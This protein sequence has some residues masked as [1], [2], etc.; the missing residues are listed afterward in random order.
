MY[1]FTIG[2]NV[3]NTNTGQIVDRDSTE[4]GTYVEWAQNHITPELQTLEF[5]SE[6][7]LYIIQQRNQLLKETDWLVIRHRDQVANGVDLNL[8]TEEYQGLLNYRQFLRDLPQT[9]EDPDEI[10]WPE[11]P[12]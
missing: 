11:W 4:W 8:A 2:M 9:F 12:E 7:W 1:R 6:K 3:I 5:D 10:V